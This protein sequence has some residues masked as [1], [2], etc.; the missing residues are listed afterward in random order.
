MADNLNRGHW[1]D[2]AWKKVLSDGAD[3][4]IDFFLPELAKD[5][6]RSK[7]VELAGGELPAI[8]SDSDRR[9][10]IAD[11]CFSVPLTI[12]KSCKVGC[13]VEQQHDDDKGI[14]EKIF[15]GFYR[16]SDRLNDDVTALAIFTGDSMDRGE[17]RYSRYGVNLSF[18]YNTYHVMN[19]DIEQLKRDE[20]VFAPVVLAARMMMEAKGESRQREEYA[21]ELLKIMRERD[22]DNAKKRIVMRFIGHILRLQDKDITSELRGE[23]LM[24]FMPLSEYRKLSAIEDIREERTLEIARNMLSKGA[25]IDLIKEYTGLDE[26]DI[27]M[28]G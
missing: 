23:F 17:Y 15:R 11:V 8:G 2:A 13:V 27:S 21:K 5:R 14:A 1:I 24:Q 28:L 16:L 25:S 22:Y 18:G 12:G 3:D 9:A 4:A 10:R 6:D 19:Q 26:Y 7:E 20:R